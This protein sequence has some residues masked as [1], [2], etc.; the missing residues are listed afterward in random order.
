[1]SI[2]STWKQKCWKEKEKESWCRIAISNKVGLTY[3]TNT[4]IITK[5]AIDDNFYYQYSNLPYK[6]KTRTHT[7]WPLRSRSPISGAKVI[8]FNSKVKLNLMA[9]MIRLVTV[10]CV[11]IVLDLRLTNTILFFQYL[12][13]L[14]WNSLILCI[15]VVKTL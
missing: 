10:R 7:L 5:H 9:V 14:I 1:M 15:I 6:T 13:W 8:K 4:Q 3:S 11:V 2:I 12:N